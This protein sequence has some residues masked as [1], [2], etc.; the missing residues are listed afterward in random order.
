VAVDDA[1][2][3]HGRQ[4]RE[5]EDVVDAGAERKDHAQRGQTVERLLAPSI[6]GFMRR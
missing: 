1:H 2:D 4:P 6:A 5:L 3:R